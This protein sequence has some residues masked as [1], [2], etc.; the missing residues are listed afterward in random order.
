MTVIDTCSLLYFV[1]YY[2]PFDKDSTLFDFMKTGVESG[3]FVIIDHVYKQCKWTARGLIIEKLPFLKEHQTITTDLLPD[4]KFFHWLENDFKNSQ[5]CKK[6]SSEEFENEK[7]KFTED[8]DVKMLLFCEKHKN[9]IITARI[10][11]DET[12]VN[13]DNKYFKKLPVLC[14]TM[15]IESID[16][17]SFF[18]EHDLID[19]KSK[20][21]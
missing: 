21:L 9:S 6:I 14:T 16:L 7:R 5:I 4:K 19:V 12:G 17:P 15:G 18:K 10:L 8:A 1:R 13:N 20:I 11:T 2:L 3:E